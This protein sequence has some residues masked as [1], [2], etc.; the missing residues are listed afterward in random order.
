[1]SARVEH[2]VS[3]ETHTVKII[4]PVVA[5]SVW[6]EMAAQAAREAQ[7]AARLAEGVL[8]DAFLPPLLLARGDVMLE[9]DGAALPPTQTP[10]SLM[11]TAW[12]VFAERIHNDPWLWVLFRGQTQ[13]GLLDLVRS[14]NQQRMAQEAQSHGL[15]ER[16]KLETFWRLGELPPRAAQSNEKPRVLNQLAESDID[17]RVGRRTLAQILVK[18]MRQ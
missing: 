15:A 10:Q 5:Q 17:I 16:F 14:R 1:M 2:P 4:A 3:K 12:L 8:P 7:G 18:A 11:M 9:A 6:D 13:T